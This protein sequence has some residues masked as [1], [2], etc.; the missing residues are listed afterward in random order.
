MRVYRED[1]SD[2]QLLI[3]TLQ[4]DP[5]LISVDVINRSKHVEISEAA[6]AGNNASPKETEKEKEKS[7]E[8]KPDTRTGDERSE[9][10]NKSETNVVE[11]KPNDRTEI[12]GEID[13]TEDKNIESHIHHSRKRKLSEEDAS[14]TNNVNEISKDASTAKSSKH[15]EENN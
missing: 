14:E 3:E 5:E 1:T 15:N 10:T 7:P 9:S 12:K 11:F 13:E 4:I 6:E 8:P 2:L